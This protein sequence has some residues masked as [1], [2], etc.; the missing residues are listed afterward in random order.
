MAT[1]GDEHME[2]TTRQ[3]LDAIDQC[4]DGKNLLSF[5][6]NWL[7]RLPERELV[8]A[9]DQ[10]KEAERPRTHIDGLEFLINVRRYHK[11][12]FETLKQ[13]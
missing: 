12:K 5:P 8:Q 3:I 7:M 10:M 2:E 1:S 4:V 11:T 13:K 9:I 6:R